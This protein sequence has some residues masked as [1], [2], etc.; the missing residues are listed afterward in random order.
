MAAE[1]TAAAEDGRLEQVLAK[2]APDARQRLGHRL[3]AAAEDG[4]L[5]K[6]LQEK[7]LKGPIRGVLR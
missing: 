7:A 6:I 4:T 5:E 2:R 1:L 3:L